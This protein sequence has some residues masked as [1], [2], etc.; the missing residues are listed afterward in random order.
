MDTVF[1]IT[2]YPLVPFTQKVA[3]SEYQSDFLKSSF[4]DFH[5][6]FYSNK[7]NSFVFG[8]LNSIK[9]TDT[10]FNISFEFKAKL[11]N[12]NDLQLIGSLNLNFTYSFLA[13]LDKV[14]VH[15]DGSDCSFLN[16]D[17]VNAV[18]GYACF[19]NIQEWKN[20]FRNELKLNDSNILLEPVTISIIGNHIVEAFICKHAKP[21]IVQAAL[22]NESI[23]RDAG[24]E[25][26][27][28][29]KFI[30]G[31]NC[32]IQ[33]QE[34]SNTVLISAVRNANGESDERC[35]VW[36]DRIIEA[37]NKDILCDEA[38]YSLGGAYPDDNG[39]IVIAAQY[40]LSISTRSRADLPQAVQSHVGNNFSH[41]K[42]FI[43]LGSVGAGLEDAC[44]PP[45]PNSEKC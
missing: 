17:L 43:Y 3:L 11:D 21:L 14:R 37:G 31:N 8:Y 16:T 22:N 20:V 24:P 18:D 5:I 2:Q 45:D 10:D 32:L 6:T 36:K 15:F 33:I 34:F 29:V 42:D 28:Q 30:G 38:V 40:P 44:T 35:G 4:T 19:K 12:Y 23:Y 26:S 25:V 41:I 13:S 7:L 27:G 39:N 1:S 9:V